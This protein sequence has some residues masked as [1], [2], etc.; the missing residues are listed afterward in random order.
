MSI[1]KSELGKTEI[2]TYYDKLLESLTVKH[3]NINI[4]TNYG[5]TFVIKCGVPDGEPVVLLHGSGI[6]SSMWV[7]DINELAKT[8]N[9]YAIDIL[10]ECGRSSETLLSYKNNDYSNWL[11]EVL[12]ALNINNINIIGTSLGGWISL[13]YVINHPS[14]VNK[15]ILRAPAGIGGQNPLFLPIALFYMLLNKRE[16]LF[17]KINGTKIPQEMLNYQMTIN[18]YF[19]SRKDVLPLFTDDELSNIKCKTYIYVGKKDIILNSKK[20]LERS[21]HIKNLSIKMFD[22]LGHSLVNQTDKILENIGE[23]YGN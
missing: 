22:D 9:V 10:G 8:Y 20:T 15:L 3:E 16:V 6:N 12:K 23:N 19:N 18:K 1:Y 13:K 17:N 5:N 7:S 11:D 14:N 4:A 2:L 21:K